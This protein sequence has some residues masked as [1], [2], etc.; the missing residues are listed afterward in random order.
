M[1]PRV[2]LLA[3]SLDVGGAERQLVDLACGLHRAGEFDVCVVTFYPGG[4]LEGQLRDQGVQIRTAA[5]H[6]RWDSVRFVAILRRILRSYSPAIVHSY[7]GPPNL[8]AT[9]LQ[10]FL[11]SCRVVWGIRA[12]DM[13]LRHYDWTWRAVFR[14]ER[15]LS[16]FPR[17]IVA[18]S[19]AGRD[20]VATMGFPRAKIEVIPNGIDTH[21]FGTVAAAGESLRSQW[22]G[23]GRVLI[24]MAAR[25]D[26]MKDHGTF[27]H[28]ARR[29]VTAMPDVRFVC[30]GGGTAQSAAELRRTAADLGLQDSVVW[31]GERHDMP[32]VYRALDFATLTS[33]FGEGFP[34]AVGE[35]MA[36]GRPCVVTDVGDAVE[37]VGP[38]GAAVPRRDPAA[39]ADA[40]QRL[41][42]LPV[43]EL[44]ALGRAA[45]QRILDRFSI[46]AMIA[47]TT[48]LYRTI[49]QTS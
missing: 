11:P 36:C 17:S 49:L 2:V 47:R 20:Y 25:L 21:R 35:A 4:A 32:V 31:A 16:R 41:A 44:E 33:A 24:G 3:R 13:D 48:T 45:R 1:T 22:L 27:L 29:L 38:T 39:L 9:L 12:S 40:W 26:P 30:I 43:A 46:D 7:L 34:N 37:L 15:L 28:A 18:N 10:P 14:M 19:F 42:S 23:T 5:K 6:G 8:L